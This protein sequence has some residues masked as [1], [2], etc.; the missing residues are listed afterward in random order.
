[1]TSEQ[2]GKQD[3]CC[4]VQ[5]RLRQRMHGEAEAESESVAEQ[6]HQVPFV[7]RAALSQSHS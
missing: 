3:A 7:H 6:L 5:G 2:S 1:M 4:R